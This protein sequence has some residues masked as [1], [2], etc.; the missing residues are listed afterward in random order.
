LGINIDHIE[1]YL[2]AKT[3]SNADLSKQF[4]GTSE[5]DIFRRTGIKTRYVSAEKEISS[6]LA[7]NA[8]EK[9]L[10]SGDLRNQVDF[11]IYCSVTFDYSTPSTSCI[12]QDRLGLSR[13]TGCLDIGYGCS[14]YT[15]GLGVAYGLLAGGMAKKIL[16][17]TADIPSK[18]LRHDDLEMRSLFSDIGTAS[19]L[20]LE[21]NKSHNQFVFGSDGRGA[22]DIYIERSGFRTPTDEEYI[23]KTG[24]PNGQLLMNGTNIFVFANKTVPKLVEDTLKKNKLTDADIDLYVFHQANGFMLE[25]LRKKMKI[26]SE[27]FYVNIDRFGNSVSSTVPVAL[28]TASEEGILKRG[29][30]VMLVGFGVGNSWAATVVEF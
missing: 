14:G 20:T 1:I 10:A 25:T 9:L 27:K 12:L 29:M 4:P 18:V 13:Q 23:K 19:L 26:P 3:V 2:P 15:Y 22:L 30:R 28:K 17:V 24:L 16:F 8:A 5:E 6:D 21:K 7:F 11:L